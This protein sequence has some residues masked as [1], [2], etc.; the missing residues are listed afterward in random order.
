MEGNELDQVRED[1][2]TIKSAVGMELPFGWVDVWLNWVGACAGGFVFLMSVL[3]GEFNIL[4]GAALFIPI[5]LSTVVLRI[6]YRKSTGRSATRRREY[7]FGIILFIVVVA[8]LIFFLEWGLSQ[9]ISHELILGIIFFMLGLICLV[10]AISNY[11]RLCVIGFSISFM[12]MGLTYPFYAEK[13]PFGAFLGMAIAI[14]GTISA[15]IMTL[16]LR[17]QARING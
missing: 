16:Q 8:P 17:R 7:S 14:G 11:A 5:G 13:W 15:S 4:W 12:A 9:G 10:M 2:D 6:K 1:I 3:Q